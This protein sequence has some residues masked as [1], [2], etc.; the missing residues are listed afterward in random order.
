M[1]HRDALP[2]CKITPNPCISPLS[3]W[4][5]PSPPLSVFL[6]TYLL[7]AGISDEQVCD[8]RGDYVRCLASSCDILDDQV[9]TNTLKTTPEPFGGVRK[10]VFL[11]GG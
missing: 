2:P 9:H 4:S 10:R 6:P 7:S 8:R 5:G 11:E 3:L 1:H